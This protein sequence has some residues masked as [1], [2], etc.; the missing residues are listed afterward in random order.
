MAKKKPQVFTKAEK[1]EAAEHV[2]FRLRGKRRERFD[3]LTEA[4]Q[5]EAGDKVLQKWG[6]RKADGSIDW[7][8]LFAALMK[9]LPQLIELIKTLFL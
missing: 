8:A 1:K 5:L 7:D 9:Y 3:R 6:K 4:E 2:R